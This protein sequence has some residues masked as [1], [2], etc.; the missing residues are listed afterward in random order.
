[1]AARP[2]RAPTTTADLDSL[3]DAV[4]IVQ[5]DVIARVNAAARRMLKGHRK[6]VGRRLGE[7]LAEG[8]LDRFLRLDTQRAGGWAL[9]EAY[10]M[11]FV[12]P[13]GEVV[14][15]DV[16]WHRP[17]AS[18]V[19]LTARDVT[20][21]TRAEALMARLARLPLRLEALPVQRRMFEPFFTTKPR[22]TG[23]GLAIVQR[24]ADDLHARVEF[25]PN[26]DGATFVLELPEAPVE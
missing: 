15:A 13:G 12:R 10:R 2:R 24:L 9:P 25:V 1:M 16:R 11:R 17:A 7:L 8:E 4:L 21:V 14:M 22:G 19:V 26:P 6:L 3:P 18:Q 20:D 23:L 5:G